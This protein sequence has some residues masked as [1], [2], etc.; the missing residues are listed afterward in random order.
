MRGHG[1]LRH[2]WK[3]RFGV[4]DTIESVAEDAV[5]RP[6]IRALVER[7][8]VTKEEVAALRCNSWEWEALVP[9][10]DD[11]A[12]VERVEH[13]LANCSQVRKHMTYDEAMVVLYGPEL[14]KRFK[15]ALVEAPIRIKIDRV[16]EGGARLLVNGV[17]VAS[18]G[19]SHVSDEDPVRYAEEVARCLRVAVHGGGKCVACSIE[20]EIGIEENPHPVPQRFHVCEEARRGM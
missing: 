2:A 15:A 14:L 19:L 17:G 20:A 13:T 18:W 4:K 3:E 12:F 8:S 9:A 7:G 16:G 5:I 1:R 6:E 11:T 10:Y